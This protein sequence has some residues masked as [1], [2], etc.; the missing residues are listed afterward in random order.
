M[1]FH[2]L[3]PSNLLSVTKQEDAISQGKDAPKSF[4]ICGKEVPRGY[5]VR[6][7]SAATFLGV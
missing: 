3:W 1:N 6:K 5:W 7:Q 2:D 4:R